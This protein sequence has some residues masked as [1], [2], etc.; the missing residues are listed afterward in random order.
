MT[1]EIVMEKEE[2]ERKFSVPKICHDFEAEESKPSESNKLLQRRKMINSEIPNLNTLNL[3]TN[4][5]GRSCSFRNRPRPKLLDVDLDR[6]RRSSLPS[7]ATNHHLSVSF[8][9]IDRRVSS[10]QPL[11]RVRS[12]KTTSKGGIVNRGD[13]FKRS[14]NSVNSTG[15]A[16]VNVDKAGNAVPVNRQRANSTH[17]KES[18]N[19]D[20]IASSIETQVYKVAMLGD[21]GV[22]KTSLTNQFMTSEFVAFENDQDESESDRHV[23][24]LLNS[25]ESTLE[26]IDRLLD[27]QEL[28]DQCFDAFAVVYSMTDRA[29]YQ[30]AVDHLYNIRHELS[31]KDKPTILIANKIDLV[32]K[33]KVSKEEARAVAKQYDSK[34][35]ETSAALNH[36]VDELLVGILS[37][38]RLTNT[39]DMRMERPDFE[40]ISKNKLGKCALPGPKRLLNFI[41]KKNHCKTS[42]YEIENLFT[43]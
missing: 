41:F 42:A 17:S 32:R 9:D 13:S 20:S 4:A 16:I 6:P 11:Q 27:N 8:E 39:P 25:E 12:F 5:H 23:T 7:P 30:V 2:V 34:Y 24:V 43:R 14:S 15:S 37:Q 19:G 29:S 18:A 28:S 33:R 10:Q 36:H 21:K 22:G 31:I 40:A 3:N 35:A 26:I 38:I 1:K